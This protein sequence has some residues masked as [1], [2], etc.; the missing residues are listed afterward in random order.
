MSKQMKEDLMFLRKAQMILHK[1]W[2]NEGVDR[3]AKIKT[4]IDSEVESMDRKPL[5]EVKAY[6]LK[7]FTAWGWDTDK[8]NTW[9]DGQ[10]SP[11]R[12]N[13]PL[14][15]Q[16]L[17][18][19]LVAE[20]WLFKLAQMLLNSEMTFRDANHLVSATTMGDRP[21]FRQIQ[22]LIDGKR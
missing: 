5:H 20:F 19:L 12:K 14:E 15:E 8:I 7:S 1:Y 10:K 3:F 18:K 11:F 21:S 13:I 17:A 4:D 6:I 2:G 22:D 16:D 9:F